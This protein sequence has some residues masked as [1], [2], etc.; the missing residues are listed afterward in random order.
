MWDS[1][2]TLRLVM[3]DLATTLLGTVAMSL[4]AVATRVERQLVSTTRP[5]T[6]PSIMT[7]SPTLNGRSMP[8]AM[9]E[10]KSP[11][12]LCNARPRT[13]AMIPEVAINPVTDTP[14]AR[15]RMAIIAPR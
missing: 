14:K 2:G 12:V 13:M 3:R 5:S 4:V 7:T 6:A 10:N 1:E 8:I 9:P 15:S 11:S